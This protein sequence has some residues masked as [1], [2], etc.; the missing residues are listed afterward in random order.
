M[1]RCS[2]VYLFLLISIFTTR[3]PGDELGFGGQVWSL[4]LPSITCRGMELMACTVRGLAN[5]KSVNR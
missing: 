2:D 1:F 3:I 4:L 5:I